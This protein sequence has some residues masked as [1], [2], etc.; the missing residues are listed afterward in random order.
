[1]LEAFLNY[2]TIIIYYF[3][4]FNTKLNLSCLSANFPLKIGNG[5]VSENPCN[6][7]LINKNKF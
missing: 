3:I 2:I 5:C 6:Y 1:M 4:L 7:T